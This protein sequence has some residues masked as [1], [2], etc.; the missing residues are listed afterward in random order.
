MRYISFQNRDNDL[1]ITYYDSSDD[2]GCLSI[3]TDERK[4]CGGKNGLRCNHFLTRQ[5]T[6][7]LIEFL[8]KKENE[9]D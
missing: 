2:S 5:E 3:E 6:T 7:Q 4:G 9:N 1:N 8:L